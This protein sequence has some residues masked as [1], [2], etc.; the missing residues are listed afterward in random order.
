MRLKNVLKACQRKL[1][2][3][4]VFLGA[5]QTGPIDGAASPPRSSDE[6]RTA[7]FAAAFQADLA[8]N[9]HEGKG[10]RRFNDQ[11]YEVAFNIRTISWQAYEVLR[12]LI[13]LPQVKHLDERFSDDLAGLEIQI[14][15]LDH[16][17]LLFASYKSAHTSPEYI[18]ELPVIAEDNP[19]H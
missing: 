16:L 19:R 10:R 18:A 14:T 7:W 6:N 12:D 5:P 4:E 13:P 1:D 15:Q 11:T 9:L 3:R 2:L 8:H 17:P